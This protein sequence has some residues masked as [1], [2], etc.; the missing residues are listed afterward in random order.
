[1]WR[2][3]RLTECGF[4]ARLLPGL[5]DRTPS[6]AAWFE[7]GLPV[8]GTTVELDEWGRLISRGD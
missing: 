3:E 1:M 5:D 6:E 4:A 7:L 2:L 8:C